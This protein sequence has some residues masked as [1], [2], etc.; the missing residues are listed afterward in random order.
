MAPL[1]LIFHT[2]SLLALTLSPLPGH[3]QG[4][5]HPPSSE[6]V[7]PVR[8]FGNLGAHHRPITTSQPEAQ[9]F[10]DQG[11]AFLYAF[12]M[13]EAERSFRQAAR[14][15]PQCPMCHWGVAM[16]LAPHINF[17]AQNERTVAAHAAA[18]Q[19][20]AVIQRGSAVEQ[21][22]VRAVAKRSSDPAPSD[23]A[24]QTALDK[25][26]ADAMRKVT[27]RFPDDADAATL[28]A[29]GL[30]NLYPW[31]L[32]KQD[33]SPQP[34]TLEIVAA[35]EAVLAKNP[36][37]PGANHL[38]IH[39]VE[40]SNHPEK[41][42]PA[43]DRIAGLMPGAAHMV[44]MGSHIFVK[45]G[46]YAEASEVN[47]KAIAADLAY[48]PQTTNLA[49]YPMYVGHNYQFLWSTSMIEGRYH[50]A[51]E[52]ARVTVSQL[53]LEMLNMEPGLDFMLGYPIWTQVRFGR[54]A[55]ALAEPNP[56][57][58][59]PYA[60]AV[61]HGARA[62][63]FAAQGELGSAE[64]ESAM[65]QEWAK[66]LGDEAEEGFNTAASLIA[67]AEE[68]VRGSLAKHRGDI[69]SAVD[70]L[71]RAASLEDGFEYNEPPDWYFPP[72]H[73]LGQLLLEANRAGEAE[74]VFRTDLTQ[75]PENG[76]ALAGL[77][78]ALRQQG[79]TDELAAVEGRL[80]KAWGNAE[81][82]TMT[83]PK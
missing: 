44:H 65:L 34:G 58:D 45:V 1:R 46:R 68:V 49:I 76:W 60:E 56:V 48:L 9:R 33:G 26:Y 5:H 19:A 21:A 55:E 20:L 28:F 23:E 12:N 39:A 64:A 75:H 40:A 47:R 32:W 69:P 62:I 2:A 74:Q 4:H 66:K 50:E 18:K 42:L 29:E 52:N 22:L 35:L 43:A 81:G 17:P 41:A 71:Q 10:F 59:F 67:L 72:R 3:A 8:L 27:R 79:K 15:D 80:A 24:G 30:M 36:E 6:P 77:A 53:P 25:G 16:S 11:L 70:H 13:E 82:V 54:W 31:R 57:G 63:A 38:Y 51:L 73:L 78:K 37:H 7:V 61:W 14:L 83:Q